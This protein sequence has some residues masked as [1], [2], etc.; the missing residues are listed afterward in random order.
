MRSYTLEEARQIVMRCAKQYDKNLLN[1]LFLIIYRDK[2]DNQIKYIEIFF[3]KENFQHLTG[4]ELL[5]RQ[6]NVR[7]HVAELFYNKCLNNKLRKDEIKVRTDGTTNLKL[8]ALPVMMDIQ[9]VTKIEGDYN[10]YRPYLVADKIIGNVNFCLGLQKADDKGYYIPVSTLLEDIKKLTIAP[11]QVLAII[12]KEKEE[13]KY[14]RIR[15]V[16]K[17]LNLNNLKIP[18]EVGEKISLEDYIYKEINHKNI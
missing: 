7:M 6:G 13:I 18:A 5:D 11:S 12:S 16:T 9:K 14:K 15:Y 2:K 1:Q 8:A 10:N 3:G 4:V 17:G